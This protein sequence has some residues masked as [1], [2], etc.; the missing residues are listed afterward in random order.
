M[1]RIKIIFSVGLLFF[2]M[3]VSAFAINQSVLNF[4]AQPSTK[5]KKIFSL[6]KGSP[7]ILIKQQGSWTKI[8]DPRT[9]KVGWV[10]NNAMQRSPQIIHETFTKKTSN[11][12]V[13]VYSFYGYTHADSFSKKKTDAA[14]KKM[15]QLQ[16][17]NLNWQRQ[18]EQAM[19]Q[20]DTDWG[21][22][23]SLNNMPMIIIPAPI[24]VLP[25]QQVEAK[26]QDQAKHKL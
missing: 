19:Q 23:K 9:G 21:W 12:N 17:E 18:M 3:N 2:F 1:H 5:A 14:L 8:A 10:K 6:K 15:Q 16:R 22:G 7:I 26:H 24:V 11:G 25:Q 20:L 4:Y 13:N